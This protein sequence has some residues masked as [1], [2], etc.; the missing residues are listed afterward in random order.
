MAGLE[1]FSNLCPPVA[2]KGSL[3]KKFYLT[4]EKYNRGRFGLG[5][6]GNKLK[7]GLSVLFCKFE[8]YFNLTVK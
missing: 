2:F 6:F 1:K 4:I 8:C 5:N 3:E 7:L